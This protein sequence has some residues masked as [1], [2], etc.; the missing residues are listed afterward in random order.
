MFTKKRFSLFPQIPR[1]RPS[2][3]L[4]ARDKL[5]LPRLLWCFEYPGALC[6]C[7]VGKPCKSRQRVDA[8]NRKA[9]GPGIS[10]TPV[11]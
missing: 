8:D 6:S 7:L 11:R 10:N 4:S 1:V 3:L 5:V 2:S 9:W